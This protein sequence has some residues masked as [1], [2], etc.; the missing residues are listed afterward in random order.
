MYQSVVEAQ[1]TPAPAEAEGEYVE[2]RAAGAHANGEFRCVACG[3]SVVTFWLLP[4]CPVCDEGLW[5]EDA[6]SPFTRM[7]RAT[8]GVE[9]VNAPSIG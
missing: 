9:E 4:R 7:A 5:E 3:Y 1:S 8:G 2:F 6:W